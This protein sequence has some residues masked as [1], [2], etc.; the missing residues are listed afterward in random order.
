M[1]DNIIYWLWLREAATPGRGRKLLATYGDPEKIY[2][3]TEYKEAPYIKKEALTRL[4]DKNISKA[5]KMLDTCRDNGI[6]ILTPDLPSYPS[7]LLDIHDYPIV[8]FA[9]GKIPDW[10][11]LFTVGVVGTRMLSHDGREK[12]RRIC[13][14]L[15]SSGAAIIS[16]F[17]EGADTIACETAICN[18]GFTVAVL[19]CGIDIVYPKSNAHLYVKVINEGLFLSEYPPGTKP[20]PYYFPA[21]NRII[22]GLSQCVIVTEAP[23]KSG[24][25]ITGNL[26]IKYGIDLFAIPQ[27]NSGTDLLINSGAVAVTDADEIT[28]NYAN[29]PEK[30]IKEVAASGNPIL[31]LLEEGDLCIDEICTK[32]GFSMTECNSKCFMLELEGKIK[33]LPGGFYTKL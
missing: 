20:M 11:K 19:G 7:K 18:N 15:V 28:R 8:L 5:K 32:L 17:A 30:L 26:A 9:K 24:S 10:S 2:N 1:S 23:E 14:G 29:L 25:V 6:E 3:L 27:N 21:R 33:K 31:T 12:T 13:K 4:L 22:A 16:G